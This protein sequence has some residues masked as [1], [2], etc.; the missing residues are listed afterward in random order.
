M[1]S[2]L[3]SNEEDIYF[4]KNFN[5]QNILLC[6]EK[7][8]LKIL[9]AISVNKQV[10]TLSEM[11]DDENSVKEFAYENNKILFFHVGEIKDDKYVVSYFCWNFYI[12]P[13][14]FYKSQKIVKKS[15]VVNIKSKYPYLNQ[16]IIPIMKTRF[17]KDSF[18]KF[19]K[20]YFKNIKHELVTP[21]E[22]E[23]FDIFSIDLN[24]EC[25]HIGNG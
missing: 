19:L 12:R 6:L 21:V 9:P 5:K 24:K 25:K 4:S 22:Y 23:N 15:L 8:F 3:T 14:D 10:Q 13:F 11:L 2:N 18:H 20:K 17:R 16:L 7:K 1:K